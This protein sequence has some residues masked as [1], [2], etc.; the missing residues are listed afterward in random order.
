MGGNNFWYIR[1]NQYHNIGSSTT[2]DS[3]SNTFKPSYVPQQTPIKLSQYSTSPMYSPR[4]TT[5]DQIYGTSLPIE[6]VLKVGEIRRLINKYSIALIL[7]LKLAIYNSINGDDTLLY[8]KLQQLRAINSLA[9]YY[10][11]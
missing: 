1:N 3:V 6:K 5:D 9:K 11:S 10:V 2:K 7:I 4:Q 8:N